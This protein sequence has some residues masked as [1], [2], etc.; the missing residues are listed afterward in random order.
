MNEENNEQ[1]IEP[2]TRLEIFNYWTH[3]FNG[4]DLFTVRYETMIF[5]YVNALQIVL[6]NFEFRFYINKKKGNQ[7]RTKTMI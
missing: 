7:C 4:F 5:A 1:I 6:F 3:S 2:K